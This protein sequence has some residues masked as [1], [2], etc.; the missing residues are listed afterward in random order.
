MPRPPSPTPPD[1]PQVAAD[2]SSSEEVEDQQPEW[3]QQAVAAATAKYSTSR[4]D[5]GEDSSA[6]TSS[7]SDD[8]WEC[9]R[10]DERVTE[11]G[12][13]CGDCTRAVA[14]AQARAQRE[15]AEAARVQERA[16]FANAAAWEA[17][18]AEKRQMSVQAR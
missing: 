15:L 8:G 3:V 16:A 13:R 4:L 1:A 6:A 10:C 9:I 11:R 7:T 17:Y 2:D 12:T 18:K 14:I 5:D